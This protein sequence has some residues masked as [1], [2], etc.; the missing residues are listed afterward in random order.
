MTIDRRK[1]VC[2]CVRANITKIT[3]EGKVFIVHVT[4]SEV[5]DRQTDRQTD[6][7][8]LVHVVIH[9]FRKCYY[10]HSLQPVDCVE[11]KSLQIMIS[12]RS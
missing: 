6:S 12:P 4:A 7:E 11:M 10:R 5:R 2:V 3:Y 9:S 1:R 8:S